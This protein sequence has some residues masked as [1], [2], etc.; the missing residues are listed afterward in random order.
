MLDDIVRY[1]RCPACDGALATTPGALR[2]AVGH[3][4]DIA[5]GGYVNLLA[6]RKAPSGD[7]AD[8]VAARHRFL[9][10]RWYAPIAGAVAVAAADAVPG[11]VVDAGAGTGYYLAAA[12]DALPQHHG[13]ALDS[14]KYA[15]RRAARAHPRIGA[16]AVDVW[17]RLPIGSAGA[18][19][20]MC[21]FAPRNGAEFARVLRPDG[22]LLLVTPTPRHLRE[23]VTDF[24][25]LTVDERKPQRVT[26]QLTSHF[27]L[28]EE[29]RCE[30]TMR[31]PHAD[32]YSLAT[33][34][35]NAFHAAPEML[36]RRIATVPEPY[37]VTMSVTVAT[38]RPEMALG[39]TFR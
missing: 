30:A 37:E 32:L 4:H 2:C 1:L 15:L 35:P 33:M 21:V 22:V 20:V 28:V 17:R 7:T 12:L 9:S 5:R 10:G 16:A 13:I 39:K 25:L 3:T 18:A 23:A 24:G 34:G 19:V 6:G 11:V 8:M 29:N 27:S 38:Y 31:L 14:S 36:L 26:Q